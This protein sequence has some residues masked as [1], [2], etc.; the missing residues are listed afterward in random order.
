LNTADSRLPSGVQDTLREIAVTH[1][2]Y[3]SR[4]SSGNPVVLERSMRIESDGVF[5][6]GR[7][8]ASLPEILE[9]SARRDVSRITKR[10]RGRG[11]WGHLGM[12]GGY[13]VG[14]MAGGFATSL[15]CRATRGQDRCDTGAFLGGMLIG[16]IAGGAY[17]FHAARRETEV[18]VY[19]RR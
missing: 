12:L 13:F 14:G 17:G 11:V 19:S 16:G 10:Q 3:L 9:T 15:A 6:D 2:E 5:I 1:P 18:V 8:L 7:K 4:A